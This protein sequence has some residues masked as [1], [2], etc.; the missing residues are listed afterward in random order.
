MDHVNLVSSLDRRDVPHAEGAVH[1][2]INLYFFE[3]VDQLLLADRFCFKDL[4]CKNALI[5]VD[6]WPHDRSVFRLVWHDK[7]FCQL[8]FHYRTKLTFADHLV[9]K[10]DVVVHFADFGKLALLT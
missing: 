5:W 3:Y 2:P 4:T 8:R 9:V 10:D 6:I 1:H 7:V